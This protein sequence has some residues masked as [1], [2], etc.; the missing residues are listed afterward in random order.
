[1]AQHKDG[2]CEQQENSTGDPSAALAN[3]CKRKMDGLRDLNSKP[4]TSMWIVRVNYN[5][6]HE[7]R[8]IHRPMLWHFELKPPGCHKKWLKPGP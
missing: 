8:M 1:M 5:K 4:S 6:L 2:V 3:R 7:S